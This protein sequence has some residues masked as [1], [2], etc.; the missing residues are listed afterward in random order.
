[1]VNHSE[2]VVAVSEDNFVFKLRPQLRVVN[3]LQPSATVD[4]L[5]MQMLRI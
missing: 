2:I 1:M 3:Y 5:Q 4:V